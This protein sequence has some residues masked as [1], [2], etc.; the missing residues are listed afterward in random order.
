MAGG[1]ER[2][3]IDPAVA[4]LPLARAVAE[5]F[6]GVEY[7]EPAR[8]EADLAD[9]H[10]LE[11]A[12]QVLLVTRDRGSQ[13]KRCP[14]T[15]G[16]I[17]C[18]YFVINQ[19]IGCPFDCSY[20]FLQDYANLPYSQL[21]ANEEDLQQE[22]EAYSAARPRGFFRIGTGEAT[23]SLALDQLT[24][25]SKRIVPLFARLPNAWLE[26]KTKSDQVANLEGL[27][28]GGHTVVAWSLNPQSII[29]SDEQGSA[30]L[31]ARLA[32][33]RR[34][35]EAGYRLAFHFDPLVL[36][37]GWEQ[38]YADVVEQLV[39]AVDPARIAWISLGSFRYRP[40]L[41]QVME[42]RF[43]AGRLTSGEHV[44]CP[45]GKLRYFL[46]L[47][48]R[49]YRHLVQLLH[50]WDHR[51]FLYLCMESNQVWDAVLGR[52]PGSMAGVDTLFRERLGV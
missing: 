47:R 39:A 49:L 4:A 32:A 6:P 15:R 26:L 46:P 13:L 8:L 1:Y 16:L 52:R 50:A 5:R 28:H 33:A 21:F 9:V 48:V 17:C 30:P 12:K 23:D 44:P 34:V 14:G 43:P 2:I 18:N 24:G 31:V 7:L 27:E 38:A 20:C 42:L 19:G 45:D 22:V 51:L 3:V 11:S 29:D 40:S 25:F 41:K 37:P 36:F 35:Q 10:P